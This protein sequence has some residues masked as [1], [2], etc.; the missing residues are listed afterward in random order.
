MRNPEIDPM[1]ILSYV[2]L[3]IIAYMIADFETASMFVIGMLGM[4]MILIHRRR[5]R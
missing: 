2:I 5:T 3:G 4:K 1:E